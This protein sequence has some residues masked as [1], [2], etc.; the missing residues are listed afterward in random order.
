[1]TTLTGKCM[2]LVEVLTPPLTA[3]ATDTMLLLTLLP[4]RY[5]STINPCDAVN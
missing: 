3:R 5:N 1:M 4:R 2:L